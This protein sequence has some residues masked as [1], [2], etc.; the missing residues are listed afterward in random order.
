[1]VLTS[2]PESYSE[3]SLMSLRQH[4]GLETHDHQAFRFE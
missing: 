2:S 3:D 4:E 1:M